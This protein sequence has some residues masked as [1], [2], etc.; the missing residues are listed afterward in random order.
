MTAQKCQP[1]I[2]SEAAVT[3]GNSGITS[4]RATTRRLDDPVRER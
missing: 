2:V 3:R 4:R 1:R